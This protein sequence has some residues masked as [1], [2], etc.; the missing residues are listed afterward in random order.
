M[1]LIRIGHAVELRQEIEQLLAARIGKILGLE[2]IFI[3]IEAEHMYRMGRGT[4]RHRLV[5]AHP[6]IPRGIDPR[7]GEF[8]CRLWVVGM[9]S[10]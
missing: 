5:S 8:G 2:V 6:V 10:T 3:S 1:G 9:D 4:M 7:Y